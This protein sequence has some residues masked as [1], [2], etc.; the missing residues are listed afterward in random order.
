MKKLHYISDLSIHNIN[1]YQTIKWFSP[2]LK[3]L[4]QE[5]HNYPTITSYDQYEIFVLSLPVKQHNTIIMKECDIIIWLDDIFVITSTDYPDIT[6]IID[7]IKSNRKHIPTA[8]KLLVALCHHILTQMKYIEK[9]TNTMRNATIASVWYTE[10]TIN[11]IMKLKL[12]TGMIKSTIEPI[13]DII[14]HIFE[15]IDHPTPDQAEIHNNHIDYL[16]KQIKSQINFLYDNISIIADTSNAI[17]NIKA[18]N[19]MKILTI[20]SAIFIPLSFIAGI[21]GMN[22]VNMPWLDQLWRYYITLAAMLFIWLWQLYVF[23]KKKRL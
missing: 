12:T 14:N 18:N 3:L 5:E 23:S 21:F 13:S 9:T 1:R 7:E 17:Q 22:F 8:Y 6:S 11:D 2:D 19:I 4:L 10:Q 15:T 16:L 20:I